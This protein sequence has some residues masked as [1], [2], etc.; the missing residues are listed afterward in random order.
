MKKI[1]PFFFLVLLGLPALAQKT[2]PKIGVTLSGGGAKGLAH[3]G[4]LKAIDSAGLNISYITGTSMGAIIGSLYAVGYSGDTIEK[5][6][7][8]IDWDLL[9][10]NQSGL[11]SLFM[12]EKD[13]YGKYDIELPWVKSRFKISTGFLEGEEL[14]LKLSELFYPVNDIKDF[15]K[16]SIPFNCIA[17]DV[18]TGEAVVLK[19]GEIVSAVRSSM[20]IPSV[21]TAS[22]YDGKKLVDGGISRNFPVRDVKQLGA[23]YVI[24]STVAT[25]L[26]P[27]DKVKN[28]IHLLLQIAFFREAED[29]KQEVPLCDIYIPFEMPDYNMGSFNSA[30]DIMQV[31][32]E[33]GRAL[34]PQLRH[35][36]DSLDAIYGV[37][38]KINNRLPASK[39]VKVSSYEVNGLEH[40]RQS[41]FTNT[42]NIKVNHSYTADEMN[43]MVRKAFG[44]RY[45]AR[46]V[47]SIKPLP[48]GS[49]RVTFNVEE[50]PLTYLKAGLHYNRFSGIGLIGNITTRNFFLPNSRS[51]AAINLG[52][53]FRLKAEHL[54]YLGR[55]KN[56]GVT[57]KTQ[58]D[59][60]DF[61]T[62]DQSKQTGLYQQN[63][64]ELSEK[65]HY[66]PT[67]FFTIGAGHK[68]EWVQYD[69]TILRP[70]DLR[71][72]TNFSSFL[73]YVKFNTLDRNNFPRRGVKIDIE[74]SRVSRQT[75]RIDFLVG[76]V[77]P[78]DPD[79]IQIDTS[80][81]FRVWTSAEGYLPAGPKTSLF[82]QVQ[83]GINFNYSRN[84]G[85]EFIIGGM[86]RMFR[87]QVTFAGLQEGALYST[88]M[89]TLQA[90]L[91]RQVFPGAYLTGRA[92]VLFNNFISRSSFF[93]NRDFYSGYA[94]TFSYN[95]ALGPLDLSVMYCDQ[96]RK[97]Q[98]YINLGIPF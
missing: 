83:Q 75:E 9:L 66:S 57:L 25:G 29:H 21:F 37:E 72:S 50:N 65:L 54:Q 88:A 2:R 70:V 33:R 31:G 6:A 76:G 98:T 95:F 39:P 86:T 91:R 44:T 46:I 93:E 36:K 84:V 12:E 30:I 82:L 15:S 7:H 71:G 58:L 96:T 77:A 14:W 16:F 59:R 80:P 18:G 3:I 60:F 48:D 19:K 79:S 92:N 28:I 34:Y 78:A 62:Y 8:G 4:I 22:D 47:Y 49:S 26:L 61:N 67:R 32:I 11:R 69:P 10:S 41:F 90:G 51:L 23:D 87:N 35:L 89:A 45:Y 43:D 55:L 74:G 1:L 24:G 94:L 5:L 38:E 52:E 17:T 73:G 20:S 81:Y 64:W 53:T 27:S 97:V 40:T 42:M 85:N 63:N 13:E 68:F 56:W